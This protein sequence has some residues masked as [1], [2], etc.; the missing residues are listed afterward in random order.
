MLNIIIKRLG[1][2]IL[3]VWSVGT[4]TFLLTR[5]LPGDMAYRIAASRYGY[6]QT[7]GVA[8]ELVRSELGLNQSGWQSYVQWLTDLLQL[9]LGNSLVSGDAVWHE[10]GHQFGHTLALALVA[11]MFAVLI[12]PPLGL[13]A[14]WKP[15]GWFD[16]VTLL[17]STLLRSVPA[18][19]IGIGLISL[20]AV[21]LKWLP[22]AGYGGWQYFILPALTLALGLSAV[23]IRVSRHAMVEV[24]NTDYY[25]FSRLK[26]L[27]EQLSFLRHGLR[28]VAIPVLAY[29]SVQ[30]IYLI[31]GVVIVESL[32]A[33]P[34][35]GHALVHAVIA[36]DVPMIQG[37]C[38]IMGGIF[39]L[40][41]MLVDMLS[42]ALDPRVKINGGRH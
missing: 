24:M 10:I 33:W 39:V 34:G 5:S 21:R 17:L 22:A 26:G 37:T 9:K 27:N 31:E 41:N 12:G 15:N 3:V 25:Q 29:H 40:L 16:R 1:Q 28:N 36:R 32:F 35:S 2:I 6:D 42:G 23:S 13:L 8:A 11:L 38:L 14:A 19:I 7:D 18:F 4:L 20:F 30:L